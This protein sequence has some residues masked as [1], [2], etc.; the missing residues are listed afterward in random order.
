M[1]RA[2]C[3]LCTKF[4]FPRLTRMGEQLIKVPF[5]FV[6]MQGRSWIVKRSYEDFRVLDKHLHLCIYD[7]RFSQLS[8]LPRSD[9]L[10]DSPEVNDRLCKHAKRSPRGWEIISSPY[11]VVLM[12]AGVDLET[13]NKMS[14]C[15][16][17]L[18]S[19]IEREMPCKFIWINVLL[20]VEWWWRVSGKKLSCG[21]LRWEFDYI[22][23]NFF[24]DV[25]NSRLNV[26]NLTFRGNR[27][28]ALHK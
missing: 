26:S 18:I 17:P 11:K 25:N 5:F 14:M 16:L 23:G 7:R 19:M 12:Q 20:N 13:G 3:Y 9:A 28:A 22:F 15:F 1:A 2:V 10:K 24:N 21:S 27:A 4:Y 6:F 8:E